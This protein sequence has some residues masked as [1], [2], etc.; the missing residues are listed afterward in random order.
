MSLVQEIRN[1][2]KPRH[3]R[4]LLA[5][6]VLLGGF[7]AAAGLTYL[8]TSNLWLSALAGLGGLFGARIWWICERRHTAD[9]RVSGSIGISVRLVDTVNLLSL[10]VAD[11]NTQIQSMTGKN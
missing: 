2:V 10:E 4:R 6:C 9:K 3:L 7:V 11:L 8:G 1:L 5:L